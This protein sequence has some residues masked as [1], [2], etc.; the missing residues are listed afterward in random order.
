MYEIRLVR[1]IKEKDIINNLIEEYGSIDNLK[2]LYEKDK[3]NPNY[4]LHL[5]DWNHHKDASDEEVK[6]RKIMLTETYPIGKI[7]LQLLNSI[8]THNPQSIRDLARL[9][10]KDI[11]TVQP[12]VNK[13][14]EEGFIDLKN[15]SK[16][17]KIPVFPYEYMEIVIG[18]APFCWE[19]SV[20]DDGSVSGET[21]LSD[22]VPIS[23]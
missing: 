16:N 14:A 15:G 7:E 8:K 2:K 6:I 11:K 21:S 1:T 4:Y 12:K 17:N 10:G 19:S 18:N 13:L 23:K 20:S 5:L 3:E 22:E 9:V